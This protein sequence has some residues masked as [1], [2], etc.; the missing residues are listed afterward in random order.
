MALG[1]RGVLAA[2][3][4]ANL[5]IAL[6]H[7]GDGHILHGAGGIAAAGVGVEDGRGVR[8]I[9]DAV[10][11]GDAAL[12]ALDQLAV[13]L[14][15]VGRRRI[16]RHVLHGRIDRRRAVDDVQHIIGNAALLIGD[17]RPLVSV[18]LSVQAVRA[19]LIDD[20]H[21]GLVNRFRRR[22]GRAAKAA[23]FREG[24]AA[25]QAQR[26]RSGKS[27]LH[28][29]LHVVSFLSVQRETAAA[30]QGGGSR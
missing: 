23:A 27:S 13:S 1:V 17:E 25:Q 20:R 6:L 22:S 5:H 3:T 21:S 2:R 18:V 16:D 26:E 19:A 29:S 12:G 14:L 30:F 10:A 15:T 11:A 28:D 8:R 9:D 24:D 7:V 4:D